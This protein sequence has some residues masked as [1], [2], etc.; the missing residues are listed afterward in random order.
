[1]TLPVPLKGNPGRPQDVELLDA[2][3]AR[4]GTVSGSSTSSGNVTGRASRCGAASGTATS[5]ASAVGL[6]GRI[7]QASGA[8]SSTGSIGASLPLKAPPAI[9]GGGL[10]VWTPPQRPP[11]RGSGSAGGGTTSRGLVGAGGVTYRLPTLT[12]PP[13][14]ST[15]YATGHLVSRGWVQGIP[16]T[17]SRRQRDEE[18]L[19]ALI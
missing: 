10:N 1:M 15:G 3:L 6:S 7:G 8:G 19:L 14:S 9:G 16:D 11:H 12:P 4:S 5:T 17:R 13:L 2:V 18:A